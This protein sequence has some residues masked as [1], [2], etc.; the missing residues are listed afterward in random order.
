[1]DVLLFRMNFILS[2]CTLANLEMDSEK[3]DFDK[4][5]G[6]SRDAETMPQSLSPLPKGDYG[7]L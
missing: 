5:P 4:M 7:G 3:N 1:M 6:D 2:N